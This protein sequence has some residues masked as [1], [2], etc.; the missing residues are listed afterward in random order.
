MVGSV[1]SFDIAE[2]ANLSASAGSLTLVSPE[3]NVLG[4]NPIPTVGSNV[5]AGALSTFNATQLSLLASDRLN[6]LG[7]VFVERENLALLTN[8]IAF[9][10]GL[11]GQAADSVFEISD[12]FEL[13][14]GS[15]LDDV[16]AGA[17]TVTFNIGSE[18]DFSGGIIN[19]GGFSPGTSVSFDSQVVNVRDDT[20]LN[21][22]G[23][24]SVATNDLRFGLGTDLTIDTQSDT[25]FIRSSQTAD[26]SDSISTE[27]P[28]LYSQFILN[29]Q[30]NIMFDTDVAL[31]SG[32]FDIS[33]GG[34]NVE[35]GDQ[36]RVDLSGQLI[37][38]GEEVLPTDGGWMVIDTE[39]GDIA[40]N[41]SV[42]PDQLTVNLDAAQGGDAGLLALFAETGNA[43]LNENI[44]AR[45]AEGKGGIFILDEGEIAAEEFTALNSLLSAQGF[46]RER[47]LR[48]RTG[49]I[50]LDANEEI[51]AEKIRLIA[52]QGN[53]NIA[54][55]L[56][57]DSDQGGHIGLIAQ[58]D[59][60]IL[61][62]AI[63]SVQLL[64]DDPFTK[65][66]IDL[67]SRIGTIDL[68]AGS[69]IKLSRVVD[70]DL[71]GNGGDL[72]I[73]ATRG[74]DTDGTG[75]ADSIPAV[76][77]QAD[78]VFVNQIASSIEGE[79]S[80]V[81]SG[82]AQY[83][84]DT[85]DQTLIDGIR[86]DT[87]A[88]GANL[89]D[90]G[91]RLSAGGNVVTVLPRIEI[92][93]ENSISL[94]TDWNFNNWRFG[95]QQVAPELV[96]ASA[97]NI[98]IGSEDNPVILSDGL[99]ENLAILSDE[100]NTSFTLVA[101]SDLSSADITQTFRP[102]AD[103]ANLGSIIIA[104]GRAAVEGGGAVRISIPLIGFDSELDGSPFDPNGGQA[105]TLEDCE[106][107]LAA[108]GLSGTCSG[109]G[110]SSPLAQTGIRSGTGDIHLIAAGNIEFGNEYSG[111]YTTG[112]KVGTED[113]DYF[114]LPG[115]ANLAYGEQGGNV[116]LQ[117]GNDIIGADSQTFVNDWIWKTD[118]AT[119]NG[120]PLQ[121][122]AG[123]AA[124]P[125]T[126]TG[127]VATLGGGNVS[128][129]AGNDLIQFDVSI[130]S[131]GKQVGAA[132]RTV[133]ESVVEVVGGGN[134][135]IQAGGD[136]TTPKL[137]VGK[138]YA[139]IDAQGSVG[140][141]L[142]GGAIIMLG[143]AQIDVT[144]RDEIHIER[145]FNP[146]ILRSSQTQLD[147]IPSGFEISDIE[148]RFFTYT[149]NASVSLTSNTGV[150]AY[151]TNNEFLQQATQIA[152]VS[153]N[154][155]STLPGTV[156]FAA[157]NNNLILGSGRDRLIAFPNA[158]GNFDFLAG[159]DITI[160]AI[161]TQLDLR[162]DLIPTIDS[163][164]HIQTIGTEVV[165][166]ISIFQNI[167]QLLDVAI[168]DGSSSQQS[169]F[170]YDFRTSSIHAGINENGL[171]DTRNNRLIA[172]DSIIFSGNTDIGLATAEATD[173]IA[174]KDILNPNVLIQNVNEFDISTL[175]AGGS[176]ATSFSL[177]NNGD[178]VDADTESAIFI[179]GPGRLDVITGDQ[180]NL[181]AS[182]GIIS[183][184]NVFN[185]SLIDEPASI[186]ILAGFTE[187]DTRVNSFIDSYIDLGAV[188]GAYDEFIRDFLIQLS[189]GVDLSYGLL[190]TDTSDL[191]QYVN[192]SADALA[193][194]FSGLS[195][196]DLQLLDQLSERPDIIDNFALRDVYLNLSEKQQFDV[197]LQ[198]FNNEV[199]KSGETALLATN[200]GLGTA[201]F[202][203]GYQQSFN[204]I[205]TLFP[206]HS[207]ALDLLQQR[208]GSSSGLVGVDTTNPQLV[209]FITELFAVLETKSS[210]TRDNIIS[211]IQ[212]NIANGISLTEAIN[213]PLASNNV[214][215][216]SG[217]LIQVSDAVATLVNNANDVDGQQIADFVQSL[218][219]QNDALF[220]ESVANVNTPFN[221]I[222]GEV[223]GDIN[224]L[225]PFGFY[226]VGGNI[227][228]TE[229]DLNRSA[230][231]QGI[232]SGGGS[233]N[234]F[235]G[236]D[237]F[238]NLQRVVG[239][240][241]EDL[242]LYS[243]FD[244]IDAGSGA[245]TTIAVSPAIYTYGDNGQRL[246]TFAPSFAGSG[247][248]KL[249]DVDGNQT[250]PGLFTPYG[251][252][253]AGDAGIV[254]DSGISIAALDVQNDS[255]ISQGGEKGGTSA[256]A[257]PTTPTVDAG[258]SNAATNTASS[259]AVG[260]GSGGE[261]ETANAFSDDAAAF[262]NVFV[263]GLG[264][265]SEDNDSSFDSASANGVNS[266]G[267]DEN[268][269]GNDLS[270][271][272]RPDEQGITPENCISSL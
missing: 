19:F 30:G 223:G 20:H 115:I 225:V 47:S 143:D 256:P 105:S 220:S 188:D 12:R 81:V 57:A 186:N 56:M 3:I 182:L 49:D 48:S 82:S 125:A 71:S 227:D 70:G 2:S 229:L 268:D 199:S 53:I 113:E 226:N 63:L 108:F 202:Y 93:N 206:E 89:D 136:I 99:D 68:E 73:I 117:A 88:F 231:E 109:G 7:Q 140:D 95:S 123:W 126:F 149:D 191:D 22:S 248:R 6:L 178:F 152:D 233:I 189:E 98:E 31:N 264:D 1:H 102:S 151:D 127:D 237:L 10:E 142:N 40:F 150:L 253:D 33:T 17:G 249:E 171:V 101:G 257:A 240:G 251:I 239:I 62:G 196:A 133:G 39:G 65:S 247:I 269:A 217:A 23:G 145:I 107:V 104:D 46:N 111:V 25:N 168:V 170:N 80:I 169:L 194:P 246:V 164:I 122:T 52:D 90:I 37:S 75:G 83:S 250:Q 4:N 18:I 213:Q 26:I 11:G 78:E 44:S 224:V 154:E 45:S 27:D 118:Q 219:L 163:S 265:D 272:C 14:G 66:Q 106:G 32:N 34:G 42:S 236:G 270:T 235:L 159:K 174:G 192:L 215:D 221:L 85:I 59:L 204:A 103:L 130:A 165:E 198:A 190:I 155:V 181:G 263:I 260:G 9:F 252:V 156:K 207:G 228:T 193:A 173:L 8:S 203:A 267:S 124:N 132:L 167:N 180:L 96:I 64:S 258:A 36:A 259:D 121:G 74:V 160:D 210:S 141:T 76:I 43:T 16:T 135:S 211:Q 205:R 238:V 195:A 54:G 86:S 128:I 84:A 161:V 200:I 148:A 58:Q 255:Q 21:F 157:L 222:G 94:T 230:A 15:S 212:T 166:T 41:P 138:G 271:G 114:L 183:R 137:Y 177:D 187:F 244:N 38:I 162:D 254:S 120:V 146:T 87:D 28:S 184:G 234:L 176:I 153:A 67:S 131:I 35:F 218:Q 91:L 266:T 72:N 209:E 185:T 144:A 262:L 208:V 79:D 179:D 97:G 175:S 24:L 245:K 60:N 214:T 242:N 241:Q 243:L 134:L 50:N 201:G 129:S 147:N 216:S 116:S 69:Q 92:Q 77:Q 172:N 232:I 55:T 100:F 110:G 29:A 119:I 61:D 13:A 158:R 112:R 139:E 197:V 5:T 261:E 51:I